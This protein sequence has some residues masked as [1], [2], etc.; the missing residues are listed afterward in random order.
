MTLVAL[1]RLQALYA[2]GS[3]TQAE[4]AA[5]RSAVL[6]PAGASG[7]LPPVDGHAAQELHLQAAVLECEAE[8]ARL[9]REW[10]A[11]AAAYL[12]KRGLPPTHGMALLRGLVLLSAGG[13]LMLTSLL[14]G[15]PVVMAGV[16]LAT[17]GC[18]TASEY[19]EGRESCE[20]RREELLAELERARRALASGR[21]VP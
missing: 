13:W 20:R 9:E 15:A 11:T 17:Y 18:I 3:L 1:Q 12:G 21:Q 7:A 4:Y 8:L 16:A 10:T 19:E 5:A 6:A 2:A 14:A